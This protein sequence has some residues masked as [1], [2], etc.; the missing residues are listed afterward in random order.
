MSYVGAFLWDSMGPADKSGLLHK[1]VRVA[2]SFHEHSCGA[3]VRWYG[4]ILVFML[5]TSLAGSIHNN[6]VALL[7]K[8][9]KTLQSIFQDS[10]LGPP[11][12]N[13][14]YRFARGPRPK[15]TPLLAGRNR[16]SSKRQTP[17]IFEP[18]RLGKKRA[19]TPTTQILPYGSTTG[20]RS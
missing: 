2:R 11:G 17:C 14:S 20:R 18:F 19:L 16:A 8:Q 9:M 5:H 10:F 4:T 6:K 12:L 13:S 3:R 15:N 7:T 1:R